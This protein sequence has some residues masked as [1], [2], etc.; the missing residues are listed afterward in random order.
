MP[1]EARELVEN[2]ILSFL[3]AD[4]ISRFDKKME[5]V[6]NEMDEI[7]VKTGLKETIEKAIQLIDDED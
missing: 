5:E 7:R 4:A 6:K 2:T 1:I 3:G